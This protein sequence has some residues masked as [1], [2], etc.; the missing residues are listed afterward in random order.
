M[1]WRPAQHEDQDALYS[2]CLLSADAGYEDPADARTFEDEQILG[3]VYVGPYLHYPDAV[4]FTLV[5]EAHPVGYL[6]AVP[7]TYQFDV[8]SESQWWPILRARYPKPPPRTREAWTGD[9]WAADLIHS[10]SK[11]PPAI[12]ETYPAHFHIDLLASARG[13]GF[14]GDQVRELLALLKSG[15]IPGVHLR[16]ESGNANA[17]SFYE[18]LGFRE[19]TTLA[20][21]VILGASLSHD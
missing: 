4:A 11:L 14:A 15:D 18:Y 6:L 20:G 21:E 12:V 13:H 9:Q 7:D 2:V 3:D 8:W 5:D 17:R 1:H 10:P 16:M 19:I